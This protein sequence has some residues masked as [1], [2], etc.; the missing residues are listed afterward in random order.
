MGRALFYHLT[1]SSAEALAPRLV[2]RAQDSSWR[3]ELRGTDTDVM[4]RLDDL[5]WLQEGFLAHGCAGAPH[6]ARQPILLRHVARD[7]PVPGPAGN[8]AQCILSLD[9]A[10]ISV[11]D[12]AEAARVC[13]LF[14]GDDPAALDV[15]RG[16]WRALVAAGQGADYWS[17]AS[18]TW[19][20][21]RS[22]DG[23]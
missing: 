14:R 12:C 20:K 21:E 23:G 16:Q 22:S 5:L 18:G 13:I 2:A 15:A 1:R 10:P 6:E 19:K 17:E 7:A 11:Q 9:G 8:G 4:E 3:V